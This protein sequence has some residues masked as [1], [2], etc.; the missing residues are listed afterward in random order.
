VRLPDPVPARSGR[1][2]WPR[3]RPTRTRS[4]RPRRRGRPPPRSLR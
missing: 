2:P 4:Y 3:S 1:A